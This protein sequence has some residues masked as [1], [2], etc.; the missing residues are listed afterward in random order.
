MYVLLDENLRVKELIP[1]VNPVFPEVPIT[2]RYAKQFVDSLIYVDD[3]VNIAQGYAF[4]EDTKTWEW[5]DP[6]A[7]ETAYVTEPSEMEQLRADVD[8]IL[9]Q[10]EG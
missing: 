2:E 1:D 9:M 10:M 6:P 3:D 7:V 8:F 5:Q 4:N